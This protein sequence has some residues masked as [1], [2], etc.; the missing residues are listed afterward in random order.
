MQ[1]AVDAG[2]EAVEDDSD[3]I[4]IAGSSNFV[5]I[6]DFA[7]DMARLKQLIRINTVFIKTNLAVF[8]FYFTVVETEIRSG[9]RHV[10]KCR[11]QL[12]MTIP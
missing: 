12:Q 10:C 1:R 7:D 5:G 8:H 6:P 11:V 2:R 4:L 3:K 9:S